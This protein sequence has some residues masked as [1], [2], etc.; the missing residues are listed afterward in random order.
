MIFNKLKVLGLCS[1][2]NCFNFINMFQRFYSSHSSTFLD[3]HTSLKLDK[4][5][6][7]S[8][9]KL[10]HPDKF[11][12][13]YQDI[14]EKNSS[15]LQELN[16]YIGNLENKKGVPYKKLFFFILSNE[17]NKNIGFSIELLPLRNDTSNE[18]IYKHFSHLV[19]LLNKVAKYNEEGRLELDNDMESRNNFKMNELDNSYNLYYNKKRQKKSNVESGINYVDIQKNIKNI[20]DEEIIFQSQNKAINSIYTDMYHLQQ[21]MDYNPPIKSIINA[22]RTSNLGNEI[23]EISKI[24]HPNLIIFDK[25]ITK[26]NILEFISR[27]KGDHLPNFDL[28]EKSKYI[29][30]ISLLASELITFNPITRIFVSKSYSVNRLAGFFTIPYNFDIENVM[31]FWGKNKKI[32]N[33]KAKEIVQLNMLIK[34]I[35]ENLRLKYGI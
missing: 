20:F 25:I 23:F 1:F 26:E 9:L 3:S 18:I 11:P 4:S 10:I 35:I 13:D 33:Q 22:V 24:I 6:I 2:K 21:K 30:M 7:T 16:E 17:N 27:I 15:S 5:K 32:I 8:F 28:N 29:Q 31:E 12:I 14:I 19:S 34:N